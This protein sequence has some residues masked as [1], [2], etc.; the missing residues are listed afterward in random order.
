MRLLLLP[1]ALCVAVALGGSVRAKRASDGKAG[2]C[3]FTSWEKLTADPDRCK[4]CGYMMYPKCGLKSDGRAVHTKPQCGKK[5]DSHYSKDPNEIK[6]RNCLGL[7]EIEQQKAARYRAAAKKEV[8]GLVPNIKTN[9]FS[10]CDTLSDRYSTSCRDG[11]H[12]GTTKDATMTCEA[13][14]K[15]E[16]TGDAYGRSAAKTYKDRMPGC[17]K[18]CKF[19]MSQVNPDMKRR[20]RKSEYEQCMETLYRRDC[21]GLRGMKEGDC[22]TGIQAG[23]GFTDGCGKKGDVKFAAGC[24]CMLRRGLLR[25]W[26]VGGVWLHG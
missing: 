1:L 8:E 21:M 3:A 26:L 11:C 5:A 7:H 19:D 22:R 18:G 25:R 14:C 15:A 23:C 4:E 12:K 24:E 10:F 6:R 16:L 13:K 2:I 20:G 17:V 9:C